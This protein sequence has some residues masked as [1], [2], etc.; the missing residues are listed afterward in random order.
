MSGTLGT[1]SLVNVGTSTGNVSTVPIPLGCMNLSMTLPLNASGNVVAINP[2]TALAAGT[3]SAAMYSTIA[4]LGSAST[5][6]TSAFDASGLAA[7]AQAFSIQRANQT[8]TQ[9]LST[10][11]DAGTA[12]SKATGFFEPAITAGTTLQYW[13]GDK[14]W[15]T[16]NSTAVGLG[17]VENTAL[18][19][20]AGSANLTT[21]G[22]IVTGVWHGSAIG[23]TYISS[24]TTWNAKLSANQT[25]T[26]S[27]DATGSGATAITVTLA[28]AGTA[29]T[30][31]GLT[32][33]A[34]GRVTSGTQL[35]V[36]N[37]P[38]RSIV[39]TA[40]AANGWQP[41]ATQ[42]ALLSYSVNITTT[43]TIGGASTGYVVLEVC[44]TN[45]SVAA[46]WLE[47]GRVTNSQTIT[48]AIALQ[49]IQIIGGCVA[50][51]IPAGYYARLRSVSSS[52]SPTF[53]YVSGQ[54]V[55]M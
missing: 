34:K 23:D 12:A 11:S 3:L 32:T 52:G 5:Q 53:T 7:A 15:Q 19:T 35:S 31:T 43:A 6:S 47:V 20:W 40:A 13:R 41:S 1:A 36:N 25:V 8:G 55:L 24:A 17:S 26:L 21:L 10:I 44:S 9:L 2:A 30:Y 18:S 16:L 38:A 46:N 27:G 51:M 54:E 28:N 22:T 37:A 42:N 48:L 29:G 49:S 4:G 14:S 39:T 33:D 50:C 45:S